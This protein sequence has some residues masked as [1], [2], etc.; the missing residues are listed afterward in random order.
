VLGYVSTSVATHR[1]MLD[2]VERRIVDLIAMAMK[3]PRGAFA[4]GCAL[5]EEFLGRWR[6]PSGL[7]AGPPLA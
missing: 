4:G 2:L 5:A 3:H 6:E 7:P 1:E